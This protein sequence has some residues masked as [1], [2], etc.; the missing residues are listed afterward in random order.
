[1]VSPQTGLPITSCR[2]RSLRASN[3]QTHLGL[4]S[5]PALVTAVGG[6]QQRSQ[7]HR[8]LPRVQQLQ[9][10]PLP[11]SAG[12]S[13]R[14]AAAAALQ[15]RPGTAP[16]ITAR[17]CTASCITAWSCTASWSI[18]HHGMALHS[19]MRHCTVSHGTSWHCKASQSSTWQHSSC[20]VSVFL[21][22]LCTYQKW[23]SQQQEP[24]PEPQHCPAAPALAPHCVTPCAFWHGRLCRGASRRAASASPSQHLRQEQLVWGRTTLH[25][26]AT[27]CNPDGATSAAT[28]LLPAQDLGF[29][30][31]AGRCRV[32]SHCSKAGA[33]P[34]S[35][36]PQCRVCVHME[37]KPP[38][39]APD[40][41][42]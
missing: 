23:R 4:S 2:H 22:A 35:R 16:C 12:G 25:G 14:A 42:Q 36:Q 1:M 8:S 15:P 13:A 39:E 28:T 9:P 7:L 6:R 33:A 30:S 21:G 41:L 32:N 17:S 3:N 18:L 34:A 31:H 38:N 19:I 24:C 5:P 11:G 26:G 10:E 40:T 37:S 20:T 27:S 29:P